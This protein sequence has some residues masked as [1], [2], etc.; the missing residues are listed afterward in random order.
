MAQPALEA[1]DRRGVTGKFEVTEGTDSVPVAGTDGILLMNGQSGTEVDVIERD[2]DRAFFTNNP[3][4]VGN[5]RAFI[6]G[7]FELF[8]P[9]VPGVGASANDV[10]LQTAGLNKVLTAGNATTTGKTRYQPIST[11]IKSGS[12]YFW[13]VDKHIKLLGARS[14]ISSIT[15]AVGNRIMGQA[16]IQGRYTTVDEQSLPAITVYST[17]PKVI[18]HDNTET[19][20]TILPG[21]SP[22]LVWGKELTIDLGNQ[23]TSRE[24][25]S[26]QVHGITNRQGTWTLRIAR[27]ANADFNPWTL[28]DAG[29][30][31]TAYMQLNEGTG[32]YTQVGFRGQIEQISMT[33]IDG[34]LGYEL[35]G[36]CIASD[37]GGDELWI[38]FGDTTAAGTP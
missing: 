27:T 11:G 10:I 18:Q 36:R 25:T 14:T 9:T 23:L 19:W 16:R 8:A 34:D 7:E 32:I 31:I 17:I 15:C 29:T 21:G 30:L 5:K 24:Y 6:E 2:V 1:F 12:F 20:I 4:A 33:D 3:F 22:L 37:T 26:K 38:E 28:R 13:H 35:S